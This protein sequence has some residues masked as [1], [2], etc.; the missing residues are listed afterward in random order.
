PARSPGAKLL[1]RCAVVP[2]PLRDAPALRRALARLERHARSPQLLREL[3]P[4]PRVGARGRLHS[5][6]DLRPLVADSILLRH[7]VALPLQPV[8]E[9][10]VPRQTL[11]APASVVLLFPAPPRGAVALLR[12]AAPSLQLAASLRFLCASEFRFLNS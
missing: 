7:V 1:L 8:A 11:P 2:V 3:A 9:L 4:A 6:G 10:L 12:H 5:C